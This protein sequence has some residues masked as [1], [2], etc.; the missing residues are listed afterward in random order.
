MQ[1]DHLYRQ[2]IAQLHQAGIENAQAEAD[3]LFGH[4]LKVDRSY[5]FLHPYQEITPE[6]KLELE[7]ALARRLAREPLQY[8]TGTREFWSLDFD[9]SPAVLVPRPET[10]FLLDRVCSVLADAGL[11][12]GPVLDMCTGSGV[13]AVVLALELKAAPVVAVDSSPA[14]LQV[15]AANVR[16]HDLSQSI[17][18]LCSDLYAAFHADAEFRCIVANPPYIAEGDFAILSPEVRD[19]EPGPA[20]FAGKK[21]LDIIEKL[22]QQ[23]YGHLQPGGWLFLEIGADQEDAV[24][25]LF[26]DRDMYDRVAV[27]KDWS[28]RPRVLQARRRG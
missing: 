22:A 27:L 18:L 19:W 14:A 7:T 12:K 20:L 4:F 26:S 13:I 8:I 25:S 1:L 24:R 15:A 6:Q 3:Q 21:G 17:N 11:K 16:K 2:T 5:L 28:G 23:S 9:V 10:E